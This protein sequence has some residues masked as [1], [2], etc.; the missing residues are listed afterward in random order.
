MQ[1][2]NCF[3][4]I[5]NN[6]RRGG[7][8][9]KKTPSGQTSNMEGK[10]HSF[11]FEERTLE[12]GK[13]VIRLCRAFDSLSK[14]DAINRMRI[15]RREAKE[16]KLRLELLH[17]ADIDFRKRMIDLINEAEEIKRILSTIINKLENK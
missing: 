10:R 14:K 9:T 5:T 2:S 4:T 6:L 15:A 11:D 17:E 1:I 16:T 3:R 12:F 8:N 13:R 7:P